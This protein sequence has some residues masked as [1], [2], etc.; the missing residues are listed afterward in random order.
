MRRPSGETAGRDAAPP[1]Q[2]S[3]IGPPAADDA[4]EILP[5]LDESGE[6]DRLRIRRPLGVF[7]PVVEV[8][9][10]RARAPRAP[11]EDHQL[12]A[13]RLVRRPLLRAVQRSSGRPARSAGCR[14]TPGWRRSGCARRPDPS[15]LA[16]QTSEFVETASTL[17]GFAVK[18]SSFPSG[19]TEKSLSCPYAR[20][21]AVA[22]REVG[23]VAAADR[24]P[25]DVLAHPVLPAVP[26]PEEQ[27]LGD[28]RL[29]LRARRAPSGASACRPDPRSRERRRRRR[30]TTCR[31]ATSGT[32]RRRRRSAAAAR[33]SPPARSSVQICWLPP[34]LDRNARVRPSGEKAGSVSLKSPA[35]RRR[36]APPAAGCSQIAERL[37]FSSGPGRRDRVGDRLAVG[38]D[39]I[40]G[41]ALELLQVVESEGPLGSRRERPEEKGSG[42]QKGQA[43]HR[44]L[45]RRILCAALPGP[46]ERFGIIFG[47]GSPKSA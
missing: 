25:P 30:R 17:S 37:R 9:R 12:E 23:E 5:P 46:E 42:G 38:R 28:P 26:V 27:A 6:D 24:D 14:R 10:Q 20:R 2:R 11:I 40:R 15:T 4:V 39:G 34:R 29:D 7:H 22:G 16:T 8:G 47:P 44:H 32:R 43:A 19:E 21:V 33:G 36:G 1:F 18:S 45:R 31:P 3:S 13:V 35:V 41:Q